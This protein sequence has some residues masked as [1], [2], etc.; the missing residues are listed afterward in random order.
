MPPTGEQDAEA[1]QA[2]S[3]ETAHQKHQDKLDKT[4]RKRL[5]T[6]VVVSIVLV[7]GLSALALL[8]PSSDTVAI[9][10]I[11]PKE[12]ALFSHSPEIEMAMT[13]AVEELNEWGGIGNT[14][15]EVVIEEAEVEQEAVADLFERFEQ[16]VRPIAY[17]AISCELLT[18]LSP[19]VEA[20]EVPL[21]GL[22]SAPGLTEGYGW[23]FRYFIS[24]EHESNATLRVLDSLDVDSLGILYS[25][26]PHG[27]GVSGLLVEGFTASGGTVEQQAC[28]S[29]D[30]DF[31]DEIEAMIDMDAIFVVA[32]CPVMI[33]M[34]EALNESDYDGYLMA[35][36]CASS[37]RLREM[38][39]QD[40]YYASAP[41]LYKAENILAIEFTE[42]FNENF[43]VP[44]S[45]H[46]AVGY[47]IVYL[48]H[49]L[50]EGHELTREVLDQQLEAGFVFSGVMGG[51]RV[52][53]GS[54][55]FPIPVY[56][57]IVLEGELSYL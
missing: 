43:A 29:D 11:L 24:P 46:A 57:V 12:D 4:L 14:K 13:M 48:V 49:D 1:E 30:T 6:L 35:S 15:I 41:I 52:D 9:C 50:L 36:S 42:N 38:I 51:M 28:A 47:D 23:T 19:L 44:Y 31:S 55:D 33:A 56:P 54:H 5:R 8:T 3:D 53:A 39:P 22:A 34:F 37:P 32:H 2:A 27:C 17:A 20:A 18:M 45:H 26:S 16:D 7:A 25:P 40:G 21:I 10:V